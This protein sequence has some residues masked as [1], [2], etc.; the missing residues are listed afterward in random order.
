MKGSIKSFEA[1]QETVHSTIRKDP[2]WEFQICQKALF[3]YDLTWED[4]DIC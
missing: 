2:L 3:L 1:W 4:C